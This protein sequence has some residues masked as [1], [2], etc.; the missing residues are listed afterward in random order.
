MCKVI[1]GINIVNCC[2]HDIR[3]M[4]KA[5]RIYTVP[6]DKDNLIRVKSIM[7][8]GSFAGFEDNSV[9]TQIVEF[10][11]KR[12]NKTIYIVSQPVFQILKSSGIDRDDF[13]ALGRKQTMPNGKDCRVGF[14]RM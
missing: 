9:S 3:I 13:R 10:L 8:H 5:G 14:V 4:D 11:P 1:N 12:K 6:E 2:P 7:E